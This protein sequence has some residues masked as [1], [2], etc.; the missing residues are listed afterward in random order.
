MKH[1]AIKKKR[2]A[3]KKLNRATCNKTTNYSRTR[4]VQSSLPPTEFRTSY[5]QDCFP[6]RPWRKS[7]LDCL[8][9]AQRKQ[10]T[11]HCLSL[12]F[13]DK[14]PPIIGRSRKSGLFPRKTHLLLDET[15]KYPILMRCTLDVKISNEYFIKV[16]HQRLH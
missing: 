8:P 2:K 5:G 11:R 16:Y 10:V 9:V 3:G 13:G 4:R 12:G 1:R 14:F 6:E 15:N 7:L